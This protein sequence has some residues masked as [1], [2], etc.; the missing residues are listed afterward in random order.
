MPNKRQTK[1]KL[2]VVM[3]KLLIKRKPKKLKAKN[4]RHG[5]SQE[6]PNSV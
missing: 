5:S 2:K 6:E 4:L 3:L 1:G